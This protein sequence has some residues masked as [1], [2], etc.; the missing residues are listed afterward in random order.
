MESETEP[1][2]AEIISQLKRRQ[3]TPIKA[4]KNTGILC[5]YIIR[6]CKVES[7]FEMMTRIRED[8][9]KLI[10]ADP[11][12][13]SIGNIIRRV[14]YMIREAYCE[15]TTSST[16]STTTSKLL[17]NTH[18][19]KSDENDFSGPFT[20][21]MKESVLQ[22]IIDL[23]DENDI[24]NITSAIS[25]YA[26]EHIHASEVILTYGVSET[27]FEFLKAAKHKK[28]DFSV[29]VA[30]SAPSFS[31]HTTAAKLA[32]EG[33]DTTVI[34]DSALFAV[35]ARV[36]K[37]I[38]GTHAVLA[39]GGLI[40][41]SGGHTIAIA[42]KAHAVP[43]ICCSGLYKLTPLFPHDQDT[44]NFLNAPSEILGFNEWDEHLSKVDVSVI[45][46]AYDYIPPNFVDTIITNSEQMGCIPPSYVYRLIQESYNHK[47][48]DI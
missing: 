7:T 17:T 42:A 27:V 2:M 28:R 18:S 4:A 46:P 19:L 1:W 14:L 43:V 44:F 20:N 23:I 34:S 11:S 12:E 35:M 13:L 21:E 16:T 9:K 37:V 48:I 36:N 10:A 30:E 24:E 29:F 39:N 32:S 15:D 47:D 6:K 5:R 40:T 3:L 33:I 26:L 22:S 25:D 8:G 41:H 31:G 38:I 45:N